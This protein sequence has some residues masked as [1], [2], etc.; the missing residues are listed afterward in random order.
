[1]P[2]K[3]KKVEGCQLEMKAKLK[4]DLNF[5]HFKSNYSARFGPLGDF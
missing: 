2:E 5:F 4:S 3:I 1:M